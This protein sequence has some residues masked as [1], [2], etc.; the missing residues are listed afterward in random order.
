[1]FIFSGEDHEVIENGL[2]LAL[3]LHMDTS[4]LGI[5]FDLQILNLKAP[6]ERSHSGN[7]LA[8]SIP[9]FNQSSTGLL[10]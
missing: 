8:F 10:S 7:W 2:S 3:Y 5:N 9:P 6:R 1:M 4:D